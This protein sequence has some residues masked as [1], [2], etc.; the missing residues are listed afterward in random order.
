[1]ELKYSFHALWTISRTD[2][3]FAALFFSLKFSSSRS[4]SSYVFISKDSL[5]FC[6]DFFD[7]T[8]FLS[9]RSRYLEESQTVDWS[10]SEFRRLLFEEE[11]VL[12]RLLFMVWFEF[13]SSE[14][15]ELESSL[16]VK[17]PCSKRL[18]NL[19][20]LSRLGRPVE[21]SKDDGP[22]IV[23]NDSRSQTVSEVGV[24]EGWSSSTTVSGRDLFLD[25]WLAFRSWSERM[26]LPR[27]FSWGLV[28]VPSFLEGLQGML[29]LE[30]FW[31]NKIT[32]LVNT[33]N[34]LFFCPRHIIVNYIQ[35]ATVFSSVRFQ[36][37]YDCNNVILTER[38]QNCR[39]VLP[40]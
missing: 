8:L 35:D 21:V 34:G 16:E 3:S 2:A 37:M 39:T 14:E 40:F 24:G 31:T 4:F 13:S 23:S 6:R 38:E 26:L 33:L 27:L 25:V 15:T 30:S 5:R 36:F 10:D 28:V 29:L 1:M 19:V 17:Y 7:D 12:L 22:G 11:R 9:R 20:A 32:I 18:L